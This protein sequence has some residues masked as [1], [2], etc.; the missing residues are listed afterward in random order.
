MEF[1]VV[2]GDIADE[3]ADALVSPDDVALSMSGGASAALLEAAGDELKAAAQAHA[4]L[5]AGGIAVTPGFDLFAEYVI[6]AAAT[7]DGAT[8][9]SI[10]E[11]VDRTLAAAS[12]RDCDSIVFPLIGGGVGNIDQRTSARLIYEAVDAWPEDRPTEARLI[13]RSGS[14]YQEVFEAIQE[15]RGIT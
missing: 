7:T 8:P 12:E 10:R 6:H 4:P 14:Q 3:A 1:V 15:L 9:D 5:D 13:T 2:Q 11:V